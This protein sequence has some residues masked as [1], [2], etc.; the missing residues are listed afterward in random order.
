MHVQEVA[1]SSTIRACCHLLLLQVVCILEYRSKLECQQGDYLRLLPP[2]DALLTFLWY[3][4][5][6]QGGRQWNMYRFLGSPVLLSVRFSL[7]RLESTDF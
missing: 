4:I 6:C 5:L 2:N 3:R 1:T 7:S